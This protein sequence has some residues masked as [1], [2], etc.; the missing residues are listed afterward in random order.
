MT[1]WQTFG[2]YEFEFNSRGY[3]GWY[4]CVGGRLANG[5]WPEWC[6]ETGVM[7]YS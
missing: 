4:R 3:T 1:G 5:L 6:R 2:G 7:R